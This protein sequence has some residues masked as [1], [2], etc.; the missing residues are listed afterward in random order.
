MS[1]V[2]I[3]RSWTLNNL[4]FYRDSNKNEIDLLLLTQQKIDGYEIK[5][6]ATFHPDFMSKL[7]K[8]RE[9]VSADIG[10]RAVI[11]DGI[12]ENHH[13]EVQLHNWRNILP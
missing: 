10:H 12:L 2:C 8:M 7:V 11:Y 1:K 9:F 5:S 6:S 4:F 13:S 3:L